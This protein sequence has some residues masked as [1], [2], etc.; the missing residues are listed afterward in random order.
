MGKANNV[1]NN[2]LSDKRRFADLINALL[3]GGR[4]VIKPEK[5]R[6]IASDTYE[7][8]DVKS[9]GDIPERKARYD[10][11]AMLYE[12]IVLCIFLEENQ[13]S[14][15]YVVPIRDMGYITAQYQ[16]QCT[17][18]KREH[19]QQND[20][21]TFAEKSSGFCREDHLIPVY[22]IWLYHGEAPWDGPRSL[23]DMMD[24]GNDEN[25]FSELF[26]DHVPHLIC[27]NEIKDFDVF[28]TELRNLLEAISLR[29]KKAGIKAICE[30]ERFR[31]IDA[32]TL[33][34]MSVLLNAPSLWN[35]RQKIE[36][37]ERRDF[38]VCTGMKEWEEEIIE[39]TLERGIIAHAQSLIDREGF[40]IERALSALG[41]PDEKW[42]Y[43]AEKLKASATVLA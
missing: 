6:R 42:E 18:I 30:N 23:K 33:E 26:Q 5:L 14:I 7:D 19:D 27:V 35:Q 25:G 31:H 36:N 1:I 41:V 20:Y 29:Y 32:E 21:K 43:Y 40:S 17:D 13:E 22:L 10:D 8:L 3:Y 37:V 11:L 38:D 28:H 24:F 2:Y 12:N 16:K 34:A 4:Q 15:N 9:L 39:E